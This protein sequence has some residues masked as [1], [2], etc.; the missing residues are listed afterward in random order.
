[1]APV[2]FGMGNMVRFMKALDFVEKIHHEKATEP[3]HYLMVLGVDPPR[4]GQGVG[5]TL[6]APVL[7]RADA[8]GLA[9][10]LETNKEINVKLYRKHGFEVVYEGH[11]PDGGPQ[12]WT[13]KRPPR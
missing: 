1:M 10:Y 2:K 3:H 12:L 9:C 7:A 8:S 5:S 11:L 13:M 4:Q 6:M